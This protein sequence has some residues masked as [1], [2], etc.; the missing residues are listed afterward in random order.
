MATWTTKFSAKSEYS[1]TLEVTEKSYNVANNTSVVEYKLTMACTGFVGFSDY[2]VQ[3]SLSIGGSSVWSYDASRAF[4]YPVKNGY[5][6]VLATGTK[7][8]THNTDGT[9]SCAAAAYVLVAGGGDGVSPGR[10]PSSGTLGGTLPLTTIPR[11]STATVPSMYTIGSAGTAIAVSA[12]SSAFT[13]RLKFTCG[14]QTQTVN[15][16]AGVTSYTWTPAAS[17]WGPQ[18]PTQTSRSVTVLLE[19]LSGGTVIGSNSYTTTLKIPDS[20]APSVSAT[21]SQYSTNAFMAGKAFYVAGYSAIRAAIAGALGDSYTSIAS[22]TIAGAWSKTVTTTAAS[23]TQTSG[24]IASSGSKTVTITI[25]DARGRTGTWSGSATYLAYAIPAITALSYERGTYSGGAWTAGSAGTDLRITFKA[26]CSLS[27]QGND[28]DWT[29]GAPV[30]AS[31]SAL[32]SG[33]QIVQYA[34]GIGTTTLYTVAVSVTDDIGNTTTRPITIPTVEIPFVIDHEKPAIGIGAIPQTARTL[35]LASD[36]MMR[37]NGIAGQALAGVSTSAPKENVIVPV[38]R[39]SGS[40]IGAASGS[41]RD[42]LLAL[43]P[44]ICSAYP[45]YTRCRFIGTGLC[46]VSL[47]FDFLVYS[48]SAVNSSGNP[49]YSCG[50]CIVYGGTTAHGCDRYRFG[51]AGYST[52]VFQDTPETVTKTATVSFNAGTIGTRAFTAEWASSAVGGT[53]ERA[54]ITRVS[55]STS[56]I[57]IVWVESNTVYL[58]VYRAVSTAV[59]GL[60]IGVTIYYH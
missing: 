10:A 42:F 12:A 14:S 6:E 19:T 26:T 9:G 30:S 8:I 48:T 16:A 3:G 58:R 39:V 53:P 21:L 51:T 32:S 33:T 24:V 54:E 2:R 43:M 7:T 22:Y 38:G 4:N 13:H 11:A 55:N 56:I 45:G 35:E 60:T 41:A 44:Y 1:L 5:S 23:T 46:N 49:Q 47:Y 31:G 27:G 20:W 36:W 37:T 57:P 17:T 18:F 59:S 29:I 34:T 28:M 40:A 50:D 25:K 52:Y 15:L